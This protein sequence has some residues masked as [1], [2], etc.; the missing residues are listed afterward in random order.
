MTTGT[1]GK[2][3]GWFRCV[4]NLNSGL[5]NQFNPDLEVSRGPDLFQ[6]ENL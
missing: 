2:I 1:G 4:C 5:E 3:S 6:T